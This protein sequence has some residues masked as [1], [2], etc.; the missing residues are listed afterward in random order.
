MDKEIKEKINQILDTILDGA[1]DRTDIIIDRAIQD[2]CEISIQK[3]E[4]GEATIRVDGSRLAL[5]I[6]LAGAE[7]SILNQLDCDNDEFDF[8]KERIS[9][10]E[11]SF[12]G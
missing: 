1:K 10:R 4:N 3:G 12:N 11:G 8:L 7:K 6:A 2:P 5:L 9:T